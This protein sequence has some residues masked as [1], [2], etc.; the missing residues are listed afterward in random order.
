MCCSI[1]IVGRATHGAEDSVG[2]L[3][4]TYFIRFLTLYGISNDK[5][6]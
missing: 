2:L 3:F 4:F 5:K 6:P 1:F